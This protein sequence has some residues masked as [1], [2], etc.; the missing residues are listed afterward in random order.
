MLS[1]LRVCM[2]SPYPPKMGGV[3]VQTG[4]MVD[5]LEK[6]GVTVYRV[7]TILHKL[8]KRHLL[9]LR[10]LLQPFVTGARLLR[11]A[12]K[13]D[14]IHVQAASWWGFVP[15]MVCAPLNRL[16]IRKRLV[17]SFHGGMGHIWLKRYGGLARFFF[18]M[19]DDV[20]VVSPQLKDTLANSGI[21]AWVLWNLVDL[22]RFTFRERKSIKPKVIWVRHLEDTYDPLG[23][24]AVFE[25]VKREIPEASITFVG[26]G[27]LRQQMGSYAVGHGLTDV[28]FAGRLPNSEVSTEL[29]KADIFLN[30]S[31][32]DGM[33]T[34]LLEASAAGLPIVTTDAG[35]IPCMMENGKE[36]IIVPVGDIDALAREVVGL[37]RN[38][39]RAAEMSRAARLN[40]ERYGWRSRTEDM[41][42]LYG[43]S[44]GRNDS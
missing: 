7:D 39:Y 42:R 1:G 31:K 33:P 8:D 6:Q 38:P 23:A 27:S 19:A 41:A 24:L 30:T 18:R 14:A 3:T 11:D 22:D 25:K 36:G 13:C 2:V 32:K 34:A 15:V 4:L 20:V 12:P 26:D 21:R 9:P 44:G 35:G 17:V 43:I 10:L 37:I 40:A 29:D 5:G 28:S 16:F